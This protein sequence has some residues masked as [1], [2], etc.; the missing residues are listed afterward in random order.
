MWMYFSDSLLGDPERGAF[1]DLRESED[2]DELVD[3]V[4]INL[5]ATEA[6][7]VMP[8]MTGDFDVCQAAL[9][10]IGGDLG[11]DESL[12]QLL[13]E[14]EP[15]SESL[16]EASFEEGWLLL[17]H[18]HL[19]NVNNS[20]VIGLDDGEEGFTGVIYVTR[21]GGIALFSGT[22]D[23]A[24]EYMFL[25]THHFGASAAIPNVVGEYLSGT[26]PTAPA[27]ER[28]KA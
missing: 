3:L 8:L 18:T 5:L 24:L 23:E 26:S 19:L 28:G 15:L 11:A 1:L 4:H 9:E 25:L 27:R 21:A 6:E 12:L 22:R 20:A 16:V 13:E 7:L 2:D 14:E 10:E 17:D